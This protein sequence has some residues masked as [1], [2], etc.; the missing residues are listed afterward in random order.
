MLLR[1]LT[2]PFALCLSSLAHASPFAISQPA[3]S[4]DCAGSD[5]R[6]VEEGGEYYIKA[7]F[8]GSMTATAD[9]Q[10]HDKKRCT[11]DFRLLV[12]PGW[13]LDVFEFTVDG[14]Y[15]L[16]ERGTARL[17]VSHRAGQAPAVR[18]T[19]F[20]SAQQGDAPFGEVGEG[21][22]TGAV[23][24][25]QLGGNYGSCGGTSIP[26][27][28]SVYAAVTQASSDQSGLTQLDLDEG[29]SNTQGYTICKVKP[30]PC[31]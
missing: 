10:N 17:T 27:E 21:G 25:Y 29:V 9:G 1:A 2:I 12:A 3:V 24:G 19:R 31:S 8:D 28:T 20:F 14:V 7:F 5:I 18:T 13:Q 23:Y 30:K 11:L 16:S 26:L 4:G 15:Q 22:F 6:L